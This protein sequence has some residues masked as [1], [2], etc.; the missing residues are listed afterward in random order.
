MDAGVAVGL[1][2]WLQNMVWLLGVIWLVIQIVK[3]LRRSP[4]AEREFE[5]KLDATA[6]QQRCSTYRAQ[7]DADN[8]R[9]DKGSSESRAKLYGLI[10]K[11]RSDMDEGMRELGEQT[12]ALE[13][14][15]D[16]INQRQIQMDQKIDTLLRR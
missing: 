3:S 8:L 2:P 7:N 13:V 11:L 4:P 6:C 12:A 15:T 10:E 16:M 5:S 14:K 1:D 9:R